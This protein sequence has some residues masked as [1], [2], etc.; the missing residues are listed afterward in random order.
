LPN[1]VTLLCC[2][3]RKKK[4]ARKSADVKSEI[5][6][7]LVLTSL[8][9]EVNCADS[10][11]LMRIPCISM[12]ILNLSVTKCTA[13]INMNL[14]TLKAAVKMKSCPVLSS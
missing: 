2:G 6:T 12:I 13:I 4:Q 8:Y 11:P 10:Y 14:V 1:L 3:N 5:P 7:D 9:K